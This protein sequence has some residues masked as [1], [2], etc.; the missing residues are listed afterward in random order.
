MLKSTLRYATW[1]DPVRGSVEGKTVNI[2]SGTVLLFAILIFG[3]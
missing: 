3:Y 2:D 1:L